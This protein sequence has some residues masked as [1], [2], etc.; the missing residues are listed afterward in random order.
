MKGYLLA[1]LLFT[2][3]LSFAQES[4]KVLIIPFGRL[5]FDTE[6]TLSE[7]AEI[8]GIE[9]KEVFNAYKE[10]F[11]NAFSNL[12][13][14]EIQFVNEPAAY[15][16]FK[17]KITKAYTKKNKPNYYA[18]N[19]SKVDTVAFRAFMQ[20]QQADYILFINWYRI[21][22]EIYQ[23]IGEKP[24]RKPY[25]GHFVD[26]DLY[27]NSLNKIEGKGKHRLAFGVS[28][29]SEIV[30]KSLRLKELKKGYNNFA[31]YIK[32]LVLKP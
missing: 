20:Q 29:K 16:E 30:F 23:V 31:N 15:K 12:N 13:N 19:L 22:K 10:T 3:C 17:R 28:D 18:V 5:D 25:S 14:S 9:E 7:M 11:L 27:D 26:F 6:Y 4:K 21:I 24:P 2:T 1:I 8:N 32:N